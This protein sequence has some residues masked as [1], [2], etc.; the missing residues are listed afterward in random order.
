[1]LQSAFAWP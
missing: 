1:M